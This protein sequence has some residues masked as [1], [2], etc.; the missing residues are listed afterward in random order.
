MYLEHNIYVRGNRDNREFSEGYQ[1]ITTRVFSVRKWLRMCKKIIKRVLNAERRKIHI[2][3]QLSRADITID[4]R[5]DT[6]YE[7]I[8]E[9]EESLFVWNLTNMYQRLNVIKSWSNLITM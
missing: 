5:V 3:E 1:L 6:L 8:D 9:V 4:M 7:Y 2:C